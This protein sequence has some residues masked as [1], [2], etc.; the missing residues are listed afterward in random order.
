M[1]NLKKLRTGF[2][3]TFCDTC[4]GLEMTWELQFC[5]LFSQGF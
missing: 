2:A 3:R 5:L 1:H 4:I